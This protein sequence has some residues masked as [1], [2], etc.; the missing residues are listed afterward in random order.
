MLRDFGV[1]QALDETELAQWP[2]LGIGAQEYEQGQQQEQQRPVLRP[3]YASALA[4]QRKKSDHDQDQ[5]GPMVV[6]LGP[7]DVVG[8]PWG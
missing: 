4:Q 1:L 7:G 3:R 8:I 6:V 2:D 5:S